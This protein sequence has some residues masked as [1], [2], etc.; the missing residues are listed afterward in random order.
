MLG[1]EPKK[2]EGH[3]DAMLRGE[4]L[5]AL[6]VFGH[7]LTLNEANRRFLTFLGDRNS[8]LLPPDIRKVSERSI[9]QLLVF[10]HLTNEVY[11]LTVIAGSL[12]GCNAEGQ[13]LK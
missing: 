6:A 11:C 9:G 1:W 8:P 13:H 2:G 10:S 4:I 12:C 5:N 3:L 7:D